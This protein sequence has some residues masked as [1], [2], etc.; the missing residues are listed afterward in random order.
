MTT[1]VRPD[2]ASVDGAELT[3]FLIDLGWA[4][5]ATDLDETLD[6]PVL[7]VVAEGARDLEADLSSFVPT[8]VRG[9]YVP[10]PAAIR[11]HLGHLKSYRDAVRA[12]GSPTVAQTQHVI[13]D[14]IDWIR[15]FE[16][17]L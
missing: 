8:A 16:D 5:V 9:E 6:P 11:E 2:L 15:L 3:D 14:I 13:V 10:T 7:V 12:G 4:A 17:R 1:S